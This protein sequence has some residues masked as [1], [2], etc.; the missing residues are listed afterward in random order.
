MDSFVVFR[1]VAQVVQTFLKGNHNYFV[2]GCVLRV[3]AQILSKENAEQ[4]R[5]DALE[6]CRLLYA[7]AAT[8]MVG[9]FFP[10]DLDWFWLIRSTNKRRHL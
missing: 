8:E 1:F 5:T 10:T 3:L 7:E 2:A 9:D 6:R 4:A